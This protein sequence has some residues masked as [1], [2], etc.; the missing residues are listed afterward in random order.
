MPAARATLQTHLRAAG[1]S[2]AVV[3][4]YDDPW[5]IT[6]PDVPATGTVRD[7]GVNITPGDPY[8]HWD[9]FGNYLGEA[10]AAYVPGSFGN[11]RDPVGNP[12]SESARGFARL[13]ISPGTRYD[14]YL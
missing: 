11:T 9:F 3:M 10:P 5:T 8:P 4:I 12:L 14:P 2:G 7:F 13:R 1:F 6:L